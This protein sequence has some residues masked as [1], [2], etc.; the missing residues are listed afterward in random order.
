MAGCAMASTTMLQPLLPD[1]DRTFQHTGAAALVAG[2]TLSG[3]MVGLLL[4]VP[5]SDGRDIRKL[6]VAQGVGLATALVCQA[7][8]QSASVL[9]GAC[10]AAGLLATLSAH[11]ITLG[12]RLS[13]EHKRR[14][15]GIIA[16]GI[17]L[18]M[19]LSRILAGLLA[20]QGGWRA[21]PA[22]AA[23]LILVV[24]LMVHLHVPGRPGTG[25]PIGPIQS[26]SRWGPTLLNTPCLLRS[27]TMGGCWFA[28]F[29]AFWAALA[30]HLAAAPLDLGPR[31]IGAFGALGLAG[32]LAARAAGRAADHIGVTTVIR[33]GLA[34]ALSGFGVL[35][36]APESL[37]ALMAGTALVDMGCFVAQAANQARVLGL[38]ADRQGQV[39]GAYMTTYYGAG[40]LGGAAGPLL[41]RATSWP[42]LA[43]TA[44]G[45]IAIAA[46]VSPRQAPF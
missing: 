40:A 7:A 31:A 4:I 13:P 14:A 24:V 6:I 43:L 1:L 2:S 18:G 33:L 3:T 20:E 27:A 46:L 30:I 41:L 8:A 10:F 21:V 26:L 42:I 39:Y 15:V 36:L 12:A 35:C 22:T 28:A 25:R 17:S 37:A 32:A 29:S 23:G 11:S 38:A 5:L 16:S 19:L 9:A 44:A 45:L 34:I